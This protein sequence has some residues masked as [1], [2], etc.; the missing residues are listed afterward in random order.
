[1]FLVVSSGKKPQLFWPECKDFWE[2]PAA[3]ESSAFEA[4]LDVRRAATPELPTGRVAW[5]GDDTGRADALGI[6]KEHQNP[7]ALLLALDRLRTTK[8]DYEIAC[9]AE[10][11]RR[12]SLGHA[13]VRRAFAAGG[14]SELEMHLLYL[15]TTNQDDPDTPYK[16][17]VAT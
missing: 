4:V 15:R 11:N 16:N 10:A 2:R 7:L 13:A 9:I 1:C 3:P 17:I 8:T 6:A 5:I 12:A 14:Q